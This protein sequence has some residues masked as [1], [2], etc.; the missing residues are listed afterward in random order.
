M[1]D[2]ENYSPSSFLNLLAN[3]RAIYEAQVQC[4]AY[5]RKIADDL[6]PD[7]GRVDPLQDYLQG[8]LEADDLVALHEL[9]AYIVRLHEL[10]HELLVDNMAQG[11]EYRE[12]LTTEQG[13]RAELAAR[14][15]DEL[16]AAADEVSY[17]EE[18]YQLYRSIRHDKFKH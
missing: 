18:A 16:L 14:I 8:H 13:I 11:L 2:Q 6:L 15:V 1:Q 7:L 10:V 5:G 4:E 9:G 3:L 17:D 12:H